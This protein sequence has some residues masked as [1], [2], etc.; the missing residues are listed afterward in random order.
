MSV[1]RSFSLS[2][3]ILRLLGPIV[4]VLWAAEIVLGQG[5]LSSAV[6]S[7]AN[8]DASAQRRLQETAREAQ[9]QRRI[10]EQ[11]VI[12]AP[13]LDA[14][15]L[16]GPTGPILARRALA[17]LTRLSEEGVSADDALARAGRI[18]KTDPAQAAKPT[19]YLRNLFSEKSS[20]LNDGILEK[21]EAGEDPA[22][23]LILPPYLP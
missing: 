20:A 19:A 17:A 3:R 14:T 21:L 9:R 12:L 10:Q 11:V 7:Q 16:A 1:T 15:I 18:A 22:P 23:T 6:G 13:A 2:L 5:S 8:T 4:C